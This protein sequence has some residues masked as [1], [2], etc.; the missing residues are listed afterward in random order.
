MLKAAGA[1]LKFQAWKKNGTWKK[2]TENGRFRKMRIE[3][4]G[5]RYRRPGR[6]CLTLE[7]TWFV[8]WM[9]PLSAMP[10]RRTTNPL[11]GF[12]KAFSG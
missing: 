3:N 10:S 9:V 2:N 12:R 6:G 1:P 11:E 8:T 4:P 7:T 5:G